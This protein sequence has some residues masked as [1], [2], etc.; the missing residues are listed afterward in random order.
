MNRIIRDIIALGVIALFSPASAAHAQSFVFERN[1]G[2]G[3]G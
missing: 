3:R 1:I 2:N